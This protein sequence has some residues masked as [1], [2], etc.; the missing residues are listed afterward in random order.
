MTKFHAG[1]TRDWSLNDKTIQYMVSLLPDQART[2]E[3]GA[4]ASTIAFAAQGCQHTVVTPSSDEVDRIKSHCQQ[5]NIDL[6]KVTFRI[7]PSQDV[8]PTIE[9][10]F[11]FIL[12]DGGHGFPIPY[13]DW[14]YGAQRLKVG[15]IVAVDDVHTWT[16]ASLRDFL[17]KENGWK[18]VATVDRKTAFYRLTEP[19]SYA[20]WDEQPFNRKQS[21]RLIFKR[22][23]ARAIERVIPKAEDEHSNCG[24]EIQHR[25]LKGL[26]AVTGLAMV[27]YLGKWFRPPG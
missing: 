26:L 27:W 8:M 14:F 5:N 7:A 2:L 10:P 12:I 20:E 23:I 24:P 3:T 21:K 9:G 22:K 16:G 6:S 18:H 11:D 17:A 1:G 15:G 13:L 25:F 19:F 4:G